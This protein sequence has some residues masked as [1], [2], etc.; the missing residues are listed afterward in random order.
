[1]CAVNALLENLTKDSLLFDQEQGT[2]GDQQQ[3]QH[4]KLLSC[5]LQHEEIYEHGHIVCKA[6][7][8]NPWRL[9][10]NY[11]SIHLKNEDI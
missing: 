5:F 8:D 1:L 3:F 9:G 10:M 11:D 2:H 7:I 4:L 6:L